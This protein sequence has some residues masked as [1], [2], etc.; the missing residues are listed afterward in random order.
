MAYIDAL[1]DLRL[2]VEQE[3]VGEPPAGR[4]LAHLLEG[5]IFPR[6]VEGVWEHVHQ[7]LQEIEALA[8][9]VLLG[10]D[11]DLRRRVPGEI[12]VELIQ[13]LVVLHLA[14]LGRHDRLI[15]FSHLVDGARLLS[16]DLLPSSLRLLLRSA[17]LRLLLLLLLL[18]QLDHLRPLH[19][20]LN[21]REAR[22]RQRSF[23]IMQITIRL[24]PLGY[25]HGLRNCQLLIFALPCLLDHLA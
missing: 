13:G 10:C 12:L 14:V 23:E 21:V 3:D 22:A 15:W 7:L 11:Q 4:H 16:D 5:E 1:D 8:R 24:Q 19:L 25:L 6:V 18:H 17:C 9:R 20:V 2:L